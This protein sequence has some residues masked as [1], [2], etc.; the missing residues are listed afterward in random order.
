VVDKAAA[1]KTAGKGLTGQKLYESLP[2]DG[3]AVA[4]EK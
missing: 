4:I 1:T 2:A 3:S